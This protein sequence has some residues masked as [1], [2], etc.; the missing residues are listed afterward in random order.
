MTIMMM[1]VMILLIMVMS[2][3]IMS[4]CVGTVTSFD[5]VTVLLVRCLA[6]STLSAGKQ[7]ALPS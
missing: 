5:S 1:M 6:L 2:I 7:G 4:T 3:I